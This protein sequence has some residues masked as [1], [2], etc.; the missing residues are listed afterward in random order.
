MNVNYTFSKLSI[1]MEVYFRPEY[2]VIEIGILGKENKKL[3]ELFF[4]I[5]PS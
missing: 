4:F 5:F 3:Y 2:N 1:Q